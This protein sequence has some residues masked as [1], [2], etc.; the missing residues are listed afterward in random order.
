MRT[1]VPEPYY[2]I[3]EDPGELNGVNTEKT[4]CERYVDDT[5]GGPRY[6]NGLH[7]KIYSHQFK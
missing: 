2:W 4:D 5:G 3:N 6:L 7:C 1:V